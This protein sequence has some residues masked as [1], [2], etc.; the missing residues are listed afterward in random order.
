M[1]S[2]IRFMTSDTESVFSQTIIVLYCYVI[3]INKIARK[4]NYLTAITNLEYLYLFFVFLQH[5]TLTDFYRNFH[6]ILKSFDSFDE[7]LINR[8]QVKD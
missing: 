2:G 4:G 5:I 7:N 1:N 3:F 6:N 8:F